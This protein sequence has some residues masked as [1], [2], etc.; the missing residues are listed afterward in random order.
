MKRKSRRKSNKL[1]KSRRKSNKLKKSRRKS[2]KQ[3]NV[4]YDSSVITRYVKSIGSKIY[5]TIFKKKNI[6]DQN[7]QKNQVQSDDEKLQKDLLTIVSIVDKN[8]NNIASSDS[9]KEKYN[10]YKSTVD[11]IDGFINKYNKIFLSEYY[12]TIFSKLSKIKNELSIYMFNI[13]SKYINPQKKTSNELNE[14]FN[15]Y[16][17]GTFY[18]KDEIS[19]FYNVIIKLNKKPLTNL[20]HHGLTPSITIIV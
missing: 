9:I 11:N 19:K 12:L 6:K 10:L 15:K 18:T 16:N 17:I 1:K 4:K 3:R 14:Y 20:Y 8:K 7:L 5:N 13:L 2:N